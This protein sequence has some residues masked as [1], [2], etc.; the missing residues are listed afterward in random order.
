MARPEPLHLVAKTSWWNGTFTTYCGIT[1]PRKGSKSPW[2]PS[3]KDKCAA[4]LAVWVANGG[5]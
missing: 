3:A 4:C 5:K 1:A 2:F